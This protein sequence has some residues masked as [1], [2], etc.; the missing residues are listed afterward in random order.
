MGHPFEE[1][2][3]H[4]EVAVECSPPVLV[5][6]PMP[7]P[8]VA[9]WRETVAEIIGIFELG[10]NDDHTGFVRVSIH[11]IHFDSGKTLMECICVIKSRRNNRCTCFVYEAPKLANPHGRESL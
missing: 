4:R 2:T 1:G 10:R 9:N 3:G 11:A 5:D 6:V 7:V 8:T